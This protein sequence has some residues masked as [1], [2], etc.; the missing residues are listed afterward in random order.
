MGSR[1][2]ASKSN[3]GSMPLAFR[4]GFLA[5]LFVVSPSFSPENVEAGMI[6]ASASGSLFSTLSDT[7]LQACW[8]EIQADSSIVN[9]LMA[10]MSQPDDL[11]GN[12]V[13]LDKMSAQSGARNDDQAVRQK[14]LSEPSHERF[15]AESVWID[16]FATSQLTTASDGGGC[17]TSGTSGS[18][19]SGRSMP[20]ELTGSFNGTPVLSRLYWLRTP[21]LVHV[22][23]T[24]VS[25][26]LRP[27]Q[28]MGELS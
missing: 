20:G 10:K 22:P 3:M 24:H 12:W 11:F 27:P 1:M 21:H 28:M 18:I 15:I 26:L 13:S 17:Q 4:A 5:L 25:E 7:N 8:T 9:S 23:T 14:Q 2:L 19:V 6:S 16:L